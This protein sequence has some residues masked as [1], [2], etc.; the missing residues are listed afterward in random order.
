MMRKVAVFTGSRAEYGLLSRLMGLLRDD[1]SVALQIIAGAMHYAPEFGQTWRAIVADGHRIDAR[2]ESL[3][4][5]DTAAGVVK[6]LGLGTI[7]MA[8]ALDRLAPDVL[9][10]LGDRFEALGA[11]QAALIMGIPVAHIHGGEITEGAYDDAIRHAITKMASWHFVAADAYGAR[12]IRMGTPPERVFTV[13]APGLDRLL[14][15]A[16]MPL[17]QV[18]ADLVFDLGTPYFLATYHPATSATED[19][20]AGVRAMLEALADC[21]G[22]NTVLTYPNADNG[23]RAVIAEINAFVQVHPGRA[24][25]VPS[26][27]A[28][29]GAVMAAAAAVV[30]NSSSGIIE[31]PSFRVPSVNIGGRQAGRLA[32]ASVRHVAADRA[33]IAEGLCW[34]LSDGAR[35]AAAAAINPY[36]QGNAAGAMLAVLRDAPLPRG[37][38][39]H[40]GGPA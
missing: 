29:Y 20:V 2:I 10:I 24:I 31:A 4:S 22:L 1:P 13:G 19:P 33:A 12:V 3:L 35:A 9:V 14:S 8:D 17:A 39:F 25:A 28:R 5:S 34:A 40:D 6:S 26:L 23:G 37:L 36:G 15:G 21:A 30:G 38:P 11:A 16:P 27:G 18:S 7:G 32:A